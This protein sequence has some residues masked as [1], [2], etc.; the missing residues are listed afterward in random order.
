MEKRQVARQEELIVA[1]KQLKSMLL[2]KLVLQ[3]KARLA[4]VDSMSSSLLD[5]PR[6][7]AGAVSMIFESLDFPPDHITVASPGM[8]ELA[9]QPQVI[10]TLMALLQDP[11]V[12]DLRDSE[13][14][15]SSSDELR[16]PTEAFADEEDTGSVTDE[17]T[18]G[19]RPAIFYIRQSRMMAISELLDLVN[20]VEARYPEHAAWAEAVRIEC[21]S[22]PI[23][24]FVSLKYDGTTTE[25]TAM[26]PLLA[27]LKDRWRLF[28]HV[29]ETDR[30][31]TW[32]EHVFKIDVNVSGPLPLRTDPRVSSIER[33]MI[34]ALG[35]VSLNRALGGQHPLRPIPAYVNDIRDRIFDRLE[36]GVAF[37]DDCIE[38]AIDTVGNIG[39]QDLVRR[40]HKINVDLLRSILPAS[41]VVD[42]RE[43]A[44]AQANATSWKVDR[45]G[46]PSVYTILKD[47]TRESQLGQARFH[48]A[49][50]G[51]GPTE[52][53]RLR[54]NAS[55]RIEEWMLA[56]ENDD[57]Q[58]LRNL[59]GAYSDLICH[60][61][62]CY[63]LIIVLVFIII[64]LRHGKPVAVV[65]ISIRV[66]GRVATLTRRYT[67]VWPL[68]WPTGSTRWRRT[69]STSSRRAPSS[70]GLSSSA[71]AA[72]SSKL[73]FSQLRL[74]CNGSR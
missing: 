53:A 4:T 67:H 17:M 32:T 52:E 42:D 74:I 6:A 40:T 51:Q 60:T 22:L 64:I 46:R 36:Q 26:N 68:V 47:L 54:S 73:A 5:P 14:C 27:D 28:G 3:R 31:L 39:R 33:V 9:D 23:G 21:T 34:R 37:P 25:T 61:P 16:V 20:R 41:Q 62:H 24:S 13:A 71:S 45:I 49:L 57:V 7:L 8:R 48:S 19:S 1:S 65:L 70:T 59:F 35:E 12:V 11:L 2:P 10:Q 69:T 30:N 66:R 58:K 43:L 38:N 18:D 63:D 50:A 56:V 55:G 15:R 44:E 72:W 29:A